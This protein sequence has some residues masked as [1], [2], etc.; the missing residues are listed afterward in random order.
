G[1]NNNDGDPV[2]LYDEQAGRWMVAEFSGIYNNPDYMLIAVSQTGDPTGL[3]DRWSFV[4]NGFP[5]Y[6]KLGVWSDG[7]YMGTNT[8]GGSDIYA[9][10]RSVMLNGGANPRMV[11]FDN[12]NRPASGFHCVL[13]VDNDGF[14][15]PFGTPGMFITIN[16]DAW[17][18]SDQL[19][20]YE[21][22]VNWANVNLSTF[23]RVQTLNVASFDANF[24]SSWENIVQPGT[25]QKLDAIPQVLMHRAQYRNFGDSQRIVCNHT[26]DVNGAD[27]AGIRWYELEY[28]GGDWQV[29][30]YGTYAPVG[31]ESRWMGSIAMNENKEIALG[32]S[33]SSPTVYPGIRYTGQTAAE[34][35]LASGIMD[36]EETSIHAGGASQT[37][38]ERWG[39]YANMA[40]DP[41]DN[42]TFWFTTQYNISSSQKGTKIA[43]FSFP[44]APMT[45]SVSA[46]PEEICQNDSSQLSCL[47][48]GGSGSY[49]YSWTS[50]PE[51]F[52]SDEQNPIVAPVETT[53]YFV[54]VNDGIE[55]VSDSVMI[56]VNPLPEITLGEW[57]E[58]LCNV[59]VPP[60]QLTAQPEGGIYS[61][62]G[63]SP[64]GLFDP[65]TAPIG[66]NVITYTF[67]D[68]NSCT[69]AESDSIYVDNCVGIN[70]TSPES[71]RVKIYP[72]PNNGTFKVSSEKEMNMIMVTDQNGRLVYSRKTNTNEVVIEDLKT[73]GIYHIMVYFLDG[74]SSPVLVSKEVLVQ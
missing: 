45:V 67:T 73:R 62:D 21:L 47:P 61:G 68:N 13:P 6:M 8:T 24:G 46:A 54:D 63:V 30:Q 60:V 35:T 19:W 36:I 9:F 34:N 26:V 33:V 59:G 53:W 65:Q 41:A 15:A 16:D 52:T 50:Q 3:W 29:R 40:V 14:Y 28:V 11:Q 22:D 31:T 27:R 20:I 10:E 18:Y 12:P 42:T 39:D 25:S 44:L 5:D 37:S 57:P 71:G 70:E 2:I 49:T 1:S 4:M 66:W 7:Y 38:S 69:N 48:S 74:K 64:G 72:N 56:A 43:S 51:G 55:T 32:Y 58:M 17:G 23:Q